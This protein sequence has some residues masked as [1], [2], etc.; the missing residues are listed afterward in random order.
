MT[1]PFRPR[2]VR[3]AD[4][5]PAPAL[6][7]FGHI[8]RY[9]DRANEAF[10]AKILPGE[11]YVTMREEWV[12]TVLGSCVSACIRDSI[13]AIGGMNHFMLPMRGDAGQCRATDLSDATRY[14]NFAMEHLINGILKNGGRRENLEIKLFGGGRVLAQMTDVG[15][16]NIVFVRDYIETERLRIAAED[17]GGVHPRKIMYN[18]LTGKVRMK[19]LRSM[20]NDTIIRRE[21]EYMQELDE[22]PVAGEV[23]LF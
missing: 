11:Y 15:R 19:L 1:A 16:R 14:G 18:P 7:G 6:P 17:L 10:A 21:T 20:H 23:E 3:D 13:F 12:V 22:K 5:G 8:N 9:W 2:L 4:S